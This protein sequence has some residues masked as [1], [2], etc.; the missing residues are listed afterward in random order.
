MIV[1]ESG[2]ESQIAADDLKDAGLNDAMKWTNGNNF[3]LLFEGNWLLLEYY[4]L[5][6]DIIHSG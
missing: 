4:F 2:T 3:S 6:F 5:P 1:I